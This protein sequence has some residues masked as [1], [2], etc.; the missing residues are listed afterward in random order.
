MNKPFAE[1]DDNYQPMLEMALARIR[2]LSAHEVGHTLGFAHNFEA[3]TNGRASVMDYPHPMIQLKDGEIDLT[4]AYDNKIGA[5]DKVTVAYSY[6]DIPNGK[7]EKYH[8]NSILEK[9]FERGL[10]YISDP[11]ARPKSG[12]HAKAHLWD[13]DKD[14]SKELL[15]VLS[16]RKKAIE[17]FSIDNIRKDEPLTVLEDIFVP[18]YFFHRYQ[19]EATVKLIG[20]MDYNYA[21]KGSDG[22]V[23]ELVSKDEQFK[24]LSAILETISVSNLAIPKDIIELFPPRAYEYSR[25]RESFKSNVGV[26]FDVLGAPAT[27]SRMT[28]ELLLHPER[29]NRLIQQSSLEPNNLNLDDV[30]ELLILNTYTIR[31]IAH[32]EK[33][34]GHTIRFV[35]LDQLMRLAVNE[36]SIPQVKAIVRVH[37]D[38]LEKELKKRSDVYSKELIYTITQFKKDPS[39]YKQ[40]GVPV[41]PD[42][43]PIG[44]FQCM[45]N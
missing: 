41:I 27:A 24:A 22:V 20:G 10:R 16:V 18:L 40:V 1:S 30:I 37:I 8:L 26:A 43:S 29:A 39:K 19:T 25:T 32:Y 11:D 2:Q 42:G 23:V 36:K 34:V 45:N 7:N 6:G 21:V 15:N 33:Q 12:A 31:R 28:L 9:A 35:I 17:Q 44:S 38:N 5:W 4:N 3:S 14:A 13:N